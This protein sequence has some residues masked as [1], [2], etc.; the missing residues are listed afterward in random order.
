MQV[1]LSL[2]LGT[3]MVVVTITSRFVFTQTV[4]MLPF[5]LLVMAGSYS[6]SRNCRKAVS[7][8]LQSF[9]ASTGIH[10]V[11]FCALLGMENRKRDSVVVS[12]VGIMWRMRCLK[13]FSIFRC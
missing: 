4:S 3:L 12:S 1:R 5:T 9:R 7:V 11:M 8:V 13:G 6:V 10:G 2:V